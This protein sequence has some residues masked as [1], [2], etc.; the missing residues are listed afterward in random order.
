MA[1]LS[2]KQA[3]EEA[4]DGSGPRGGAGPG[5]RGSEM[6]W[7]DIPVERWRG[8]ETGRQNPRRFSGEW[9]SYFELGVHS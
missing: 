6:K 2:A 8:L 4:A 7:K 9:E 1:P 5:P 3:Q